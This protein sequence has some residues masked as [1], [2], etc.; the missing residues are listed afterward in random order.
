MVYPG[1]ARVRIK[2]RNWEKHQI[3][4]LEQRGIK[5]NN[6][7]T[8]LKTEYQKLQ[9]EMNIEQWKNVRGP[10]PREDPTTIQD[11]QRSYS[12]VIFDNL[13]YW[14]LFVRYW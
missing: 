4:E 6:E 11:Q 3:S 5:V 7:K 8:D 13:V 10:R 1:S 12:L 2:Y 9:E 14:L